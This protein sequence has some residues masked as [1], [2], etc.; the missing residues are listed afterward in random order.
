[1]FSLILL[2]RLTTSELEIVMNTLIQSLDPGLLTV[3]PVTKHTFQEIL[4]ILSKLFTM[5]RVNNTENIFLQYFVGRPHVIFF[6][7]CSGLSRSYTVY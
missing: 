5:C 3:L 7:I 2:K 6:N 1:M 4:V